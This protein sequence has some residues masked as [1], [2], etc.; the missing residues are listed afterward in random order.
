M[1]KMA[2]KLVVVLLAAL[3][4]FSHALTVVEAKGK[5]SKG[6]EPVPEPTLQ[7]VDETL[8]IEGEIS[9]EVPAEEEIIEETEEEVPEETPAEEI[10]EETEETTE[11]V[12]P[13]FEEVDIPAEPNEPARAITGAPATAKKLFDNGDGT[14]T[15]SLSVTGAAESSSTTQVTKANVIL[16]IDTSNSMVDNYTTYN[17]TRMT[18]LAAEKRVLTDDDGII[19]SL[20]AQNVPGDSVKSDIIEVAIANFGTRGSTAQTFTSSSTQLKNTINGLTNSSGTNWEEGLMRAEELAASIKTS[21]PDEEVYIIFLTDGQPTTHNNSYSVN[22]NYATEWGYARDNARNLITAG[23]HFY[24]IY[25]WGRTQ[26]THYLSSLVQYAYTGT[27]NSNTALDAAYAQYYTNA[28][29]TE[30]IVSALN[31]IVHDITQSV[32][33]TNVE[34]EDGV[35]SM[36]TSS[37]KASTIGGEVTGVKY[38]R[39]GGSYGEA[40]PDAGNYGTEWAEAPN[41]TINEDGEV[42]WDLGSLVLE[43]GV[44]YTMTFVVWPSQESLDLVA[45]LNNG[46]VSFDSLTDDQKSQI[47]VSGGVYSL[48]T[49][50]DYPTVTYST[51]TTTIVDGEETTVVSDPITTTITN[52]DPVGLAGS[53]M[54]LR[55]IWSVDLQSWRLN[56]LLYNEDGTSKELTVKLDVYKGT[57]YYKTVELGWDAE[58][59]A[60]VW[61][62]PAETIW[63]K[64]FA[65]AP[66]VISSNP[67]MAEFAE[68]TIEFEGKTYYVLE[69]G[70]D[71]TIVENDFK[72]YH[73]D[74]VTEV[75]HPMLIDGELKTV[76]ATYEG[77]VIKSIEEVD[78]LTA[79]EATNT[80]RGG[81]NLN[82]VVLDAEG[83][84]IDSEDEF[85][86]TIALTNEKEVFV[87][88]SI[89]WFSVNGNYYHDADGN[90]ISEDEAKTLY[91]DA[92]EQYGNVL[93]GSSTAV[94]TT[95]AITAA[96]TVRIANVPVGTEFTITEAEYSAYTLTAISHNVQ[97]S[98]GS[99]LTAGEGTIDLEKRN[100]VGEIVPDRENNVTFTNQ[101]KAVFY[102]YHS[103]D[104]TVERIGMEDDRIADGKF[105]IVDETKSGYLYGGYYKA[106]GGQKKTDDEIVLAAYE[107]AD[108]G[109]YQYV[110]DHPA[111]GDWTTD[112]DATPYTGAKATAWRKASAYTVKGTDLEPVAGTVYYLKEVPDTY[113]RPY[114]QIVYDTYNS[115]SLVKLFKITATDDANYTE[116]GFND[117]NADDAS[118]KLAATIKITNEITK[119]VTTL[120]A[121]SVFG[122][123]RGYLTSIDTKIGEETFGM[124][125]YFKTLDGVKVYGVV[126]RTVD[127]GNK[128]YTNKVKPGITTSEESSTKKYE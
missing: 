21:Q 2:K 99:L 1:N 112:T 40:N 53:D 61:A 45:D 4:F 28:E 52:P 83:E 50:T 128:T 95:L 81:I 43:D 48:K 55:K 58:A 35:T 17:G 74:L 10:V 27:G 118:K 65:V 31:Q 12:E 93:S 113:L 85:E 125:P 107:D 127:P 71:Y 62:D 6:F 111:K 8:I 59:E 126:N 94:S 23:H 79:L 124:L 100:I 101:A 26:D 13:G 9:E 30:A 76:K 22:T 116:A 115:N 37:V 121:K 33:Y 77:T 41:A 60:Y 84:E 19:D 66:G 20:L 3:M 51:V 24:G 73:F 120:T 86:F 82:K 5:D 11:T 7:P 64:A 102:V 18:R 68:S 78:N 63:E 69:S 96:D 89:P 42:D 119:K 104:N 90:Y 92:Y 114:I 15:L 67:A 70:H 75:Y 29:N 38:Y 117:A 32:G 87:G 109:S 46:L 91:G 110:T 123:P 72:D 25:T 47:N 105:N 14:Y 34:L 49:N 44:T 108:S 80:L 56:G 97:L 98:N 122:V 16:V 88:D 103:S 54:K 36:T 57:E 106:Y 39:S